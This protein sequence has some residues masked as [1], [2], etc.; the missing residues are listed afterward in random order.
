MNIAKLLAVYRMSPVRLVVEAED[1]TVV[2]LSFKAVEEG[3][4]TADLHAVTAGY[5][6]AHRELLLARARMLEERSK[7][8]AAADT[9]RRGGKCPRRGRGR[10]GRG[11]WGTPA[12]CIR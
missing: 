3:A 6:G 8:R 9:V 4:L 12:G 7:P 2:E 5:R 11:C 1:G 10:S